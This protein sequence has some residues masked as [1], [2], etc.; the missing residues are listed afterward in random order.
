MAFWVS[1]VSSGI[2]RVFQAVRSAVVPRF[3]ELCLRNPPSMEPH[4]GLLKNILRRIVP[5]LN[6][7]RNSLSTLKVATESL[8]LGIGL[9]LRRDFFVQYR[10]RVT[11]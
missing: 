8:N 1:P 6:Y 11:G 7:Y 3:D 4:Q 10:R 9:E 2:D 5:L